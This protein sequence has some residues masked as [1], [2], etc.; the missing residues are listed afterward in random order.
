MEKRN[1]KILEKL[2]IYNI[3]CYRD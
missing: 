2:H 3:Q 1:T